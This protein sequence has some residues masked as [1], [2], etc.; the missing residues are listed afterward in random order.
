VSAL[1]VSRPLE[2]RGLFPGPRQGSLGLTHLSGNPGFRNAFL[3]RLPPRETAPPPC[4]RRLA[5]V[6]RGSDPAVAT[7]AA[8]RPPPPPLARG[9]VPPLR[10]GSSLRH[11]TRSSAPRKPSTR[12]ASSPLTRR[13]RANPPQ[14]ISDR[15]LSLRGHWG[16]FA[17]AR[18]RCLLAI[19]RPRSTGAA[20]GGWRK[21]SSLSAD[22][23]G[24]AGDPWRWRG[25]SHAGAQ[26]IPQCRERWRF[27]A[28][29]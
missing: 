15:A 26:T 23:S 6:L 7:L 19:A 20:S 27:S 17:S 5:E 8:R 18:R 22:T 21:G 1:S 29:R 16:G 24:A 12:R 2:G 25:H 11:R 14:K 4:R 3:R 10:G 13:L 28:K 9:C